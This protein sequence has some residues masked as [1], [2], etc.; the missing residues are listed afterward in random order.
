M[1]GAIAGDIIGSTYEI[2]NTKKKDF[3]LYR[4]FSR[5]TDDTVLTI[6]TAD[7]LLHNGNYT[8]YYRNYCLHNQMRGY[9]SRF[10]LWAL[11]HKKKPYHSMGNGSAMRISPLAYA[12]KSLEEVMELAKVSASVT[13]NH[14][15]GIKGAQ[16]IAC[17]IYLCLHNASKDEV[18]EYIEN[19]FM[20]DLA[21]TY[22]EL[23]ET[24][25]GG[26]TCPLT[27]PQAI[28]C[29]LTSTDYEDAIR[30]AIT[31]GGDSDTIACMTG[32]IAE[33]YYKEIPTYIKENTL[34]HLNPHFKKVLLEFQ[35]TYMKEYLKG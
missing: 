25:D 33:A 24:Y 32:G 6:A 3:K 21:L 29:F 8:E 35:N 23:K 17:A 13:H 18:K 9:G 2:L 5:Y 30:N 4:P 22:D 28:I 14:P 31:I 16:A 12:A 7:C 20:Y 34:N 11:L 15:E 10:Y 27:V 26:G 1:L 19:T